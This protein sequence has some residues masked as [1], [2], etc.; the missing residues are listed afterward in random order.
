MNRVLVAGIA[1]IAMLVSAGFT[2]QDCFAGHHNRC[3]GG[4][5]LSG[6][7]GGRCGGQVQQQRCGGGLLARLHANRNNCC[8]PAPVCCEAPAPAPVC[9]EAPA[10]VCC[11]AP[12]PV[13]CEAQSDCGRR[14]GCFS[15][16]R[17]RSNNCNSCNSCGGGEYYGGSVSNCPSCSQTMDS[18]TII[19][20][21]APSS[22]PPAPT[23]SE[24]AAPAPEA[25]AAP[26]A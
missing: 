20:S 1:G 9:C 19:E 26:A 25:A 8:T 4:G 11:E 16:R 15:A 24:P 7:G 14:R 18:G 5:L 12:A 21:A 2:S 23:A 3:G 17:N 22:A 13:C 6:M 10:P